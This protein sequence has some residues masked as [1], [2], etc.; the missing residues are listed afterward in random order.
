V[1]SSLLPNDGNWKTYSPKIHFDAQDGVGYA[2][3]KTFEQ[4]IIPTNG[5]VTEVP[6]LSFSYFD[7]EKRQYTT[8]TTPPIPLTVSGAPAAP[9][10]SVASAPMPAPSPLAAT[11]APAPTG[12][13]LRMNRIEPGDFVATLE[14]V[15]YNP[16]F[17]AGQALPLLALL[18]G[19]AFLRHRE[20]ES[21]PDRA[22]LSAAQQAIRQQVAAMDA[23]MRQQQAG[24]FFVHARNALQQRFGQRWNMRPEAITV[25]DID[26]RLGE[27][28]GN[29]RAVFELA[30]QA[31]Y[32]DLQVDDAD[33]LQWREVV[34]SELAEA[35]R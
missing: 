18:G 33:L 24:A 7:P 21:Q 17:V 31:T 12:P 2:G 29:A 32:S 23:A 25:S 8:C 10:P 20:R 35:K 3:T 9:A 28:G 19:L 30:D 15:Y 27:E 11:P 13:D 26:S 1:T 5:S 6:S 34:V 22:R 4:P 14:P 16:L